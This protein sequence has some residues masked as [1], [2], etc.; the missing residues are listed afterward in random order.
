MTK[1][2]QILTIQINLSIIRYLIKLLV[3][4]DQQK[5]KADRTLV[6]AD[7]FMFLL[8]TIT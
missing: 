1:A 5:I 8:R 7:P 3:R 2:T 6:V 4:Y